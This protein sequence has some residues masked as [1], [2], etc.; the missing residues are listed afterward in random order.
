[1]QDYKAGSS[2]L[3]QEV[4]MIS[5]SNK[6][7]CA[8]GCLYFVVPLAVCAGMSACATRLKPYTAPPPDVPTANL[9]IVTNAVVLGQEYSGCIGNGKVLVRPTGSS[10]PRIEGMP[11]RISPKLIYVSGRGQVES[12][13]EQRVPAGVPFLI[14]Q[15]GIFDGNIARGGYLCPQVRRVF[16]FEENKNYEAYMGMNE[17]RMTDRRTMKTCH[18][19]LVELPSGGMTGLPFPKVIPGAEVADNRCAN[20]QE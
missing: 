7:A 12:I 9:R 19:V 5:A 8:R 4:D 6:S 18:Y 13:V 17:A 15:Q 3:E 16:I 11:P 1:M 2:F 20:K 14:G 10:S